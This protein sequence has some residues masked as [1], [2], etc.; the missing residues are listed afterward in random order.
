MCG[1]S[2]RRQENVI[3]GAGAVPGKAGVLQFPAHSFILRKTAPSIGISSKGL[4]PLPPS[5]I[6]CLFP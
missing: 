1:F 5:S 2:L 6:S 3:T 4:L